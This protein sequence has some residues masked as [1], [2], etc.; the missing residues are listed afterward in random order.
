MLKYV[1]CGNLRLENVR[2][3]LC[4]PNKANSS[5]K[6]T[7]SENNNPFSI[8]P[9]VRELRSPKKIYQYLHFEIFLS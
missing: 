5:H 7:F 2:I 8:K 3:L 1:N 4:L 9:A 6:S